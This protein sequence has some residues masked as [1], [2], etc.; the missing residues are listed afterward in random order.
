MDLTE[1]S[2]FIVTN[3]NQMLVSCERG[4]PEYPG[5]PPQNKVEKR[6]KLITPK[7]SG[8]EIEPGRPY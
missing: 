8:Q 5:K 1:H 4:K 7:T 2:G 6:N 3:Q